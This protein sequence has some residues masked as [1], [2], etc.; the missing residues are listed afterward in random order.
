MDS[1]GLTPSPATLAGCS[2]AGC[3]GEDVLAGC[4][5]EAAAGAVSLSGPGAEPAVGPT[6]DD[7]PGSPDLF[8]GA[9]SKKRRR[10][11][12][13]PSAEVAGREGVPRD[14]RTVFVS[15]PQAA[16]AA[17]GSGDARSSTDASTA[18]T[19]QRWPVSEG[20]DVYVAESAPQGPWLRHAVLTAGSTPVSLGKVRTVHVGAVLVQW[21]MMQE[22]EVTTLTDA[23]MG[24]HDRCRLDREVV[25][26]SEAPAALVA[27]RRRRC[28]R[29][30]SACQN[31]AHPRHRSGPA[32]PAARV[33]RRE[34]SG[35]R[36]VAQVSSS[37]AGSTATG[38]R[39]S[40][41]VVGVCG[42]LQVRRNRVQ[43]CGRGWGRLR[44]RG[45]CVCSGRRRDSRGSDHRNAAAEQR[46]DG[47]RVASGGG[48]RRCALQRSRHDRRRAPVA[49]SGQG[50]Y[51]RPGGV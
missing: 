14:Q 1:G 16:A 2:R 29:V 23:L 28:H 25:L 13:L 37:A 48:G 47:E 38:Q 46:A 27:P 35:R 19:G 44:G 26:G 7:A 17:A 39:Q 42:Q 6:P 49:P 24:G 9:P 4:S 50:L 8:A 33:L 30:G 43:R 32:R 18:S 31:R 12:P 34:G 51:P 21:Y 20:D 36:Q 22:G 11:Q 5:V 40:G 45:G 15:A 10:V 41:L 3:S